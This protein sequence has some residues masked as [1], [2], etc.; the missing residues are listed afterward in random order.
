MWWY[1]CQQHTPHIREIPL[2]RRSRGSYLTDMSFRVVLIAPV[3]LL[4]SWFI[5][6]SVSQGLVLGPRMFILYM[7]DLA[8]LVEKC[9][10]NLT[11]R[12]LMTRGST[13]T[14]RLAVYHLPSANSKTVS[15]KFTSVSGIKHRRTS[16]T[17]SQSSTLP[18]AGTCDPP[19]AINWL[20]H[21]STCPLQHAPS[22]V[23]ASLPLVLYSLEFTIWQSAQ[24]SCWADGIWKLT[25]LLVDTSVVRGVFTYSRYT[26][27]TCTYLLTPDSCGNHW[28]STIANGYSYRTIGGPTT[29]IV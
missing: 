11:I 26:K 5:F 21:E 1:S 6:C 9:R 17:A 29:I 15:L 8:D 22:V 19:T 27:C 12:L 16:P 13:C 18:V 14:V 4:R 25:Y 2:N 28:K 10:V 3:G 23:A 20:F 24:S 7:A